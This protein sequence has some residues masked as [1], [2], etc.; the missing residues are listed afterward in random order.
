MRASVAHSTVSSFIKARESIK[1]LPGRQ[2]RDALGIL[3]ERISLVEREHKE[4][5]FAPADAGQFSGGEQA[6]QFA[7]AIHRCEF[8]ADLDGGVR[9]YEIAFPLVGFRGESGS[10]AS[11]S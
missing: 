3:F 4:L 2:H 10:G 9:R 8:G 11:T 1:P 6:A 5:T 7:G